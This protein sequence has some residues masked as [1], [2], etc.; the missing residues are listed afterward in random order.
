MP[1][2]ERPDWESARTKI[3]TAPDKAPPMVE[4]TTW[5]Q[6]APD[7]PPNPP[8]REVPKLLEPIVRFFEGIVMDE[9]LLVDLCLEHAMRIVDRNIKSKLYGIDMMGEYNAIHAASIAA[10]ISIELY[11]QVLSAI[12]K[13][14]EEYNKLYEEMTRARQAASPGGPKIVLPT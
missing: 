13:R 4:G 7:G 12:G 5:D 6:P 2:N 14:E 1:E 9:G 10:P 8:K 11:K 3:A